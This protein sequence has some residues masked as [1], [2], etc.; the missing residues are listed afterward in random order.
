MFGTASPSQKKYNLFFLIFYE[1]ISRNTIHPLNNL[2]DYLFPLN[3]YTL[4]HLKQ[5]GCH[6]KWL[7]EDLGQQMKI[8][9]HLNKQ[10]NFAEFQEKYLNLNSFINV[11]YHFENHPSGNKKIK[12]P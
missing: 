1:T 12:Q 9:C 6:R 3:I 10:I 11:P 7:E 4:K 2:I 8:F 5:K